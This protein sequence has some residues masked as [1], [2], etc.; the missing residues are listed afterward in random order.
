M[1]TRTAPVKNGVGRVISVV[2]QGVWKFMQD[3]VT[4]VGHGVRY[5]HA[6][7]HR[8]VV[9]GSGMVLYGILLDQMVL[10]VVIAPVIE[11]LESLAFM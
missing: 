11:C 2:Q 10:P 4:T 7:V 9:D 1:R 3:R 6:M 8:A 5:I